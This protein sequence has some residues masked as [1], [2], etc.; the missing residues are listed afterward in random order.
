[1]ST[2]NPD[3]SLGSVLGQPQPTFHPPSLEE[4]AEKVKQNDD[5]SRERDEENRARVEAMKEQIQQMAQQIADMQQAM[6]GGLT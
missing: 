2:I 6:Q 4:L 1:M 3:D 5:A